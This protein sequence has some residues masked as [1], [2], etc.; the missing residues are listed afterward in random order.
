MNLS[1]LWRIANRTS[2]L[3]ASLLV[4][5]GTNIVLAAMGMAT[6][7]VAAR[8]LGP[9]GRGQLVAIQTWPFFIASIAMLGTPEAL[10]YFSACSP[11]EAGRNLGSASTISL[12]ACLPLMTIGY[13][14]MPGL[15]KA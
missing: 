8:L 2:P 12:I 15:L 1:S 7:V 13:F 11:D 4:T 3:G 9:E 5:G 10:A 6:G 14:A